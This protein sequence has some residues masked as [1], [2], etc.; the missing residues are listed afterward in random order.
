MNLKKDDGVDSD[1]SRS[2]KKLFNIISE[3]N[4]LI[5]AKEEVNWV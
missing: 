2:Y 5:I 4:P 1:N 3:H